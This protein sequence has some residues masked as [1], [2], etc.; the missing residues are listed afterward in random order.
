[1]LTNFLYK[2]TSCDKDC[3]LGIVPAGKK[4]ANLISPLNS[5]YIWPASSSNSD[6]TIPWVKD[7]SIL[8]DVNDNILSSDGSFHVCEDATV[9]EN[10]NLPWQLNTA[11]SLTGLADDNCN[12]LSILTKFNLKSENLGVNKVQLFKQGGTGENGLIDIYFKFNDTNTSEINA[13]LVI[14]IYFASS[15]DSNVVNPFL[16]EFTDVDQFL[17]E[18]VQLTILID[19]KNNIVQIFNGNEEIGSKSLDI[20]NVLDLPFNTPSFNESSYNNF[21]IGGDE[22]K[23]ENLKIMGVFVWKRI[24]NKNEISLLNKL[25]V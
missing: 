10:A 12:V 19:T 22:T 3:L 9:N 4:F 18:D 24:L 8:V 14:N 17:N 5:K 6:S 1:M 11:L 16:F 25:L 23:T 7:K 21:I 20:E 2:Y 13:A 15:D